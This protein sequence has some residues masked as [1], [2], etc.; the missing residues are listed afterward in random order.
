MIHVFVIVVQKMH[1]FKEPT[2][3]SCM[4]QSSHGS[5][6][7][8]S[9]FSTQLVLARSTPGDNMSILENESV[10]PTISSFLHIA[11]LNAVI[12]TTSPRRYVSCVGSLH[13][14]HDLD[15]LYARDVH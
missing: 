3:L 12:L 4:L 6:L 10:G 14:S 9:H 11:D 8:H 1:G 15:P 5:P 2:R 13:M 7:Y